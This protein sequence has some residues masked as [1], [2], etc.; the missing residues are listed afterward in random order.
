MQHSPTDA[1]AS[2]H[3]Y[4]HHEDEP[5]H[6][7]DYYHI[8]YECKHAFR[9]PEELLAAENQLRLAIASDPYDWHGGPVPYMP[10]TDPGKVFSCPLCNHDF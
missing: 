4:Y 7:G 8:C 1:C 3:C 6:D 5:V 9:T 10:E 2:D